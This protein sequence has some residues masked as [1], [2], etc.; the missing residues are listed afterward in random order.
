VPQV[1][2][3]DQWWERRLSLITINLMS[4]TI[5]ILVLS[6]CHWLGNDEHVPN[7]QF[8]VLLNLVFLFL[9]FLKLVP[10]ANLCK[11]VRY[12]RENPDDE[13][14]YEQI[15]TDWSV[16]NWA[17]EKFLA[18]LSLCS[19]FTILAVLCLAALIDGVH[20][21]MRDPRMLQVDTSVSTF[22]STPAP[23]ASTSIPLGAPTALFRKLRGDTE[24]EHMLTDSAAG[25]G[26][27]ATLGMGAGTY[28]TGLGADAGATAG[29]VTGPVGALVGGAIG[30]VVGLSVGLGSMAVSN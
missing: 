1:S 16:R 25:V 23:M 5:S 11:A 2:V 18:K 27:G 17:V 24:G 28:Y 26:M 30:G 29:A 12:V 3:S 9:R 21:V 6:M 10:L 4:N 7:P 20:A 14:K 13:D 8:A 19:L 22:F 15:I